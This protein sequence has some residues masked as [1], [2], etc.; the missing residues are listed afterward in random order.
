MIFLF[1]G[2][3]FACCLQRCILSDLFKEDDTKKYNENQREFATTLHYYSAK[4][5]EYARSKLSLQHPRTINRY[6]PYLSRI[7]KRKSSFI[8][9][10]AIF[11]F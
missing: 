5:Y 1:N 2:G 8:D 7:R 4:A 11:F 10:K 6:F 3:I 9:I